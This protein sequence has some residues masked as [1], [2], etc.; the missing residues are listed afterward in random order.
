[1]SYQTERASDPARTEVYA[2]GGTCVATFT[3]G[4]RT[5]TL[6]GPERR[7]AEVSALDPVERSVSHALW[8]RLLPAP[9]DGAVDEAWL[10]TARAANHAGEPDV[11]ATALEYR[12]DQPLDASYGPVGADGGR[13]EGADFHD[14]LGLGGPSPMA[15]ARRI[16]SSTAASTAPASPGWCSDTAAVRR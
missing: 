2:P 16:P 1:M 15:P 9:F 5:V 13:S 8:V 14:Y 4:C 7:L 3:D 11:L 6:A 10:E 12:S